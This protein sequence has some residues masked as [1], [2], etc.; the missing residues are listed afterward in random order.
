MAARSR[1]DGGAIQVPVGTLRFV[2][3]LGKVWGSCGLPMVSK[4]GRTTQKSYDSGREFCLKG[5]SSETRRF[6]KHVPRVNITFV[7]VSQGYDNP[8]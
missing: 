5:L 2:P 1:G 8:R 3:T 6:Q 4:V 7:W